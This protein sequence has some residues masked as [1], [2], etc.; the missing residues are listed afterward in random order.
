MKAL[1]VAPQRGE[2]SGKWYYKKGNQK[3]SIG[4]T[5][6]GVKKIAILDRL[7]ANIMGI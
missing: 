5:S 1:R 3:F 6:E 4:A 2:N 7:L